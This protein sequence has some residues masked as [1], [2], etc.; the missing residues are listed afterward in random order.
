MVNRGD[1]HHLCVCVSVPENHAPEKGVSP[2]YYPNEQLNFD[3]PCIPCAF[4]YSA[5]C[6]PPLYKKPAYC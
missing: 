5:D 4:C 3:A 1:L 2:Y 6:P